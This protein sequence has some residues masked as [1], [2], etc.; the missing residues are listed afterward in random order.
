[1][2]VN[3]IHLSTLEAVTRLGTFAAAAEELGYTPGAVSQQMVALSTAVGSPV[4]ARVGRIVELTDVGR[5]IASHAH[6]VLSA[7]RALLDDIADIDTTITDQLVLGTW[8]STAA[9][10]LA[11]VLNTARHLHAGLELHSLEV[12]VDE[13]A[14]AVVRR[15]VDAAFGLYYSD[16]PL[17][18]IPGVTLIGLRSERFGVAVPRDDPRAGAEVK[19]ADLMHE[20]WVL[21]AA[22]TVYGHAMRVACRRAGFEPRVAH[23]ITDTAATLTLASRGLGLAPVTDLMLDLSPVTGVGRIELHD[24]IERE[25]VLIAPEG[26]ARRRALAALIQVIRTAVP[27][28]ENLAQPPS[29]LGSAEPRSMEGP[30]RRR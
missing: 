10:L 28:N 7:E 11:P 8:G 15:K 12:D 25:L 13:A 2:R 20:R 30:G 24:V 1:M 3:L 5:V 22:S 19:L 18:R 14:E 27:A 9:A 16:S 17:K 4:F 6:Q 23:E 26:Y 21:P 29:G